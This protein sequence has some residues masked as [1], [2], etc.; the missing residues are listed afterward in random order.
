MSKPSP[1]QRLDLAEGRDLVEELV[2]EL[3]LGQQRREVARRVVVLVVARRPL[4]RRLEHADP[5]GQVS[6]RC[7]LTRC[8]SYA[9]RRIS[10]DQAGGR[11]IRLEQDFADGGFLVAGEAAVRVH[12][13]DE[14]IVGPLLEADVDA[15]VPR[16][17]TARNARTARSARRSRRRAGRRRTGR[18]ARPRAAATLPC[19]PT[20]SGRSSGTA[21]GGGSAEWKRRCAGGYARA[22]RGAAWSAT[23]S[24]VNS[25]PSMNRSGED[26]G[27]AVELAVLAREQ[28]RDAR[29]HLVGVCARGTSGRCPP[30][31][32]ETSGFTNAG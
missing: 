16:P 24:T 20:S 31:P 12:L 3:V 27:P 14:Q 17:S 6:R 18:T 32:A 15:P 1:L 21:R 30:L 26:P 2:V 22:P 19:T 9:S 4:V 11:D 13:E 28:R 5:H 29:H 10:D 25:G 7:P 23:T 8:R